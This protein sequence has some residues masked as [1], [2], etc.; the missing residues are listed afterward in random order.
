[1]TWKL[2]K[3]EIYS[4]QIYRAKNEGQYR[5]LKTLRYNEIE[6]ID[7]DLNIN[8]IY[9]YK[10]KLVYK[11]GHQSKLSREVIVNY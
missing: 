10:I 5:L 9:R 2:P 11:T 6:Y 3:A 7:K 1:M 4:I 8:N